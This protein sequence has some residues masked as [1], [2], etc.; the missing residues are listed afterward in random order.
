M[1]G[2]A[3]AARDVCKPWRPQVSPL[4]RLVSDHLQRLQTVHDERFARDHGPSRPVVTQVADT[5][6]ACR[7]LEHAVARSSVLATQGTGA[8]TK[9]TPIE[10]ADPD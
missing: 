5:R 2:A 7:S 4:F 3:S 9:P 6:L 1:P 10:S 8:Y